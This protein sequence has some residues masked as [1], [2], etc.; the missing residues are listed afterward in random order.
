M[1]VEENRQTAAACAKP[2]TQR[3]YSSVRRSPTGLERNT[4][5][6]TIYNANN[7]Y[8]GEIM[9]VAKWGNSL[10]VRLPASGLTQTTG[11]RAAFLLLGSTT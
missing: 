3:A 8:P 2:P 10:A 5:P 11:L 7:V 6:H 4:T 1:R 9:Q